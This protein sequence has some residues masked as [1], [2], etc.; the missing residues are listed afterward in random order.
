MKKEH[1]QLPQERFERITIDSNQSE[2]IEKPSLSFWQD[3]W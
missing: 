2:R 3:A 1:E